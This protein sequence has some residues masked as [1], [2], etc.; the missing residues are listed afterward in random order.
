MWKQSAPGLSPL[1]FIL[2]LSIR[3][4]VC[5]WLSAGTNYT[6]SLLSFKRL[7]ISMGLPLQTAARFPSGLRLRLT[8]YNKHSSS[9]PTGIPLPGVLL[10]ACCATFLR[11][12]HLW[13]A[14]AAWAIRLAKPDV[15]MF[16]RRRKQLKPNL[17]HRVLRWMTFE[18]FV[19]GGKH[20]S[21][22]ATVC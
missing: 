11:P 22:Q 19:E 20:P 18:T 4:H 8:C 10:L 14:R 1:S 17:A 9:R 6:L 2:V 15:F 13:S 16:C 12:T 21:S 7:I 5:M 3:G